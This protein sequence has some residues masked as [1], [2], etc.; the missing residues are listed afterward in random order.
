VPN[1]IY[2]CAKVT[3]ILAFLILPV[4]A[5][6]NTAQETQP[7]QQHNSSS[8]GMTEQWRSLSVESGHLQSFP[9]L[10]GEL[11]EHI[12][13]TRELIQVKWRPNDP[14]YLYVIRPKGIERPPAILYLY[15]YPADL[16]RFRSDTL[17]GL[18]IKNGFAAIGFVS[19][20][21]GHRYHDRPL[22]EWFVSELQ[23]SLV[24]SVHD[25]QMI[26]NYLATRGDVDI[27]RIGMFGE[28]SGATI[29]ILASAIDAR[30]QAIDLFA[31]WGDWADWLAGSPVVPDEER[32]SYLKPEFLK[33]LASFD[34]VEWLPRVKALTIRLQYMSDQWGTP[35]A[36]LDRIKSAAPERSQ[37]VSYT[38]REAVYRTSAFLFD[39]I[40]EQL[41]PVTSQVPRASPR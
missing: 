13:F 6:L 24:T 14:I 41:C 40:K 5:G 34:P 31:P 20:L 36:A 18:L 10:T 9:P 19:A 22:R 12:D 7:T 4:Q 16:D 28:G 2:N 30:I 38:D 27:K 32:A 37:I 29:T 3:L 39:W 17:C 23:E 15:S 35:K 33:R 26:L 1:H 11:D 25:V 8:T 21:T